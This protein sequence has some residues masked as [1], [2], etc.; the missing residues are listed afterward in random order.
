MSRNC[1]IRLTAGDVVYTALALRCRVHLVRPRRW[2]RSYRVDAHPGCKHV[3]VTGIG[4][5]LGCVLRERAK[6]RLDLPLSP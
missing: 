3:G 5:G 4:L 1:C 2:T 6:S